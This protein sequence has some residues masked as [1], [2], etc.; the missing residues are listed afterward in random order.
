MSEWPAPTR[1]DRDTF[2]RVEGWSL[3]RSATGGAVAHHVTYELPLDDGRILRTRISRPV[4]RDDYGPRFWA[5]ILRDQLA[6]DEPTFWAC[7]TDGQ[8]PQRAR[9]A[10]PVE[11]L[12]VDLVVLL[13]N[14]LRLSREEIASMSRA[15]AIERINRFWTEGS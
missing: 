5:A 12:P 10:T 1:A 4:N 9:P 14:R 15:E 6:V 8:L 11:A 7:V 13:T 2:C 3:V